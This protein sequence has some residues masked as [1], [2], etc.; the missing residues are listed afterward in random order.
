[1]YGMGRGGKI[2]EGREIGFQ[3]QENIIYIRKCEN[4]GYF[5]GRKGKYIVSYF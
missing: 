4:K 2:Q 3:I 1:M 5:E